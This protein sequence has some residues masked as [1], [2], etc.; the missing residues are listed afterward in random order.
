MPNPLAYLMLLVWPVIAVAIYRRLPPMQATVWAILGAYMVLPPVQATF[1]LPAVPDLNKFTISSLMAMACTVWVLKQRVAAFPAG[2]IAPLL[3]VLFVV[4]PFF[5]AAT[6][7]DPIPVLAGDVP[8]LRLYDSVAYVA[9]QA[10]TLI[11]FVLARRFLGS[12]EGMRVLVVAL[13]GAGLAYSLPMLLEARLSPQLN[14]WIYGFFAHDFN[15]TIRGGGFRPMVFMPHGLWVAFFALMAAMSA[16]LVL[17]QAPPARRHIWLGVWLW[18]ML[19]L[20]VCRS[21]GPAAYAAFLTPLILFA[22]RRTQLLV[23]ATMAAIVITYPALRGAH[24][25]PLD[26]ILNYARSIS[27]ERAASLEYRIANE[28]VLLARAQEKPWFGWGGYGRA[29]ILDPITG[30]ILS[31]PDGGWVIVLGNYGWLGYIAQFGLLVLPLLRLG[32]VA[33]RY[34]T[35]TVGPWGAAMAL[36]YGVNLIDLLP[37]NTLVPFTWLMAGALTGWAEQLAADLRKAAPADPAIQAPRPRRT[38][39]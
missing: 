25:V 29:L 35:L 1:D 21:L 2:V 8:A 15:Q 7:P 33:L 23:A 18:L 3:M 10:I 39:L 27:L 17:R 11:P 28:E 26:D 31:V 13:V 19:M 4:S 9:S 38:I 14:V 22:P 12:D 32:R 34:R 5:T 37:N 24:M 20:A 6:N 30:R 16:L 36:I